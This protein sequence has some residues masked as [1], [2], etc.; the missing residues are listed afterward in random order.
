MQADD[1]DEKRQNEIHNWNTMPMTVPKT[2]P[3][4]SHP[5]AE[6]SVGSEPFFLLF[7]LYFF[8]IFSFQNITYAWRRREQKLHDCWWP[9][10]PLTN[11]E[12]THG[13]QRNPLTSDN[14]LHDWAQH[15]WADCLA[16]QRH[17]WI[18]YDMWTTNRC[19]WDKQILLQMCWD[20][21]H[22]LA[23]ADACT[24]HFTIIYKNSIEHMNVPS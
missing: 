5:S 3:T 10:R 15:D 11:F 1:Q 2:L 21:N 20:T 9:L 12:Q 14:T 17:D 4:T 23:C 18:Q 6:P 19:Q 13:L 8:F 24:A 7:I 22:S 16:W